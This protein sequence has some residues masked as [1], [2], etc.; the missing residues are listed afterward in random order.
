MDG[1]KKYAPSKCPHGKYKYYCKACGGK[2]ICEH[3]RQKQN[4]ILC[5]GANICEHNRQKNTC[6]DCHGSSVCEHSK[7]RSQCKDCHGVGICQ[8]N[9]QKTQCRQCG[10]GS[11]CEHGTI[12]SKCVECNGGCICEH[13]KCRSVCK[14]CNGA[15]ICK[16][17]KYKAQCRECDGSAYCVHNKQRTL[18]VECKGGSICEHG[19]RRAYCKPCGGSALCKTHLCETKASR[20]KYQGYCYRCFIYTFPDSPMVRNHK[21]K[22]HAVVAYL[23]E[24][25]PDYTMQFD[26]SIQGGCSTKKPDV[27]VD[28]GEYVM[29]IEVDENQHKGSS[30]NCET[31]RLMTL[32]QDA[33]SRPLVMIR[34]NP[35]QYYDVKGDMISSCWGYTKENGL[36]H[37]KKNK[38]KEWG[39][40]LNT[41][42]R[43]IQYQI[44]Y[45]GE[46]KEVDIIHLFYDEE[47]E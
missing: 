5:K 28:F 7:I 47:R 39:E 40:R 14:Q 45:T 46:R 11:I 20:K 33:G 8:H 29:I 25:F 1:K 34:F 43:A 4:C 13:G 19:V 30:Y 32:F 42:K 9:I 18:C 35:D 3:D 22:E 36:C 44:D 17:G 37:V 12:R 10:G 16:H 21:T 23:R 31:L 24:Q 38:K 2:G 26:K 41:L 27:F 6:K 15:S